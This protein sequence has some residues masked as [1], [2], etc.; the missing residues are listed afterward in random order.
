MRAV[1]ETTIADNWVKLGAV[2]GRIVDQLEARNAKA[3]PRSIPE[4]VKAWLADEKLWCRAEGKLDEAEMG[5]RR[6][7]PIPDCIRRNDPPYSSMDANWIEALHQA[8]GSKA[9][10]DER[11]AAYNAHEAEIATAMERAGLTKH[12]A[13]MEAWDLRREAEL[14]AIYAT[15]ATCAADILAKLEIG[16]AS[17]EWSKNV[18]DM[19]AESVAAAMHDL[20][21]MSDEPQKRAA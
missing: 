21:R 12:R 17:A 13:A 14:A 4:R 9:L 10:R 3:T 19:E 8:G 18:G 11:M 2:V 5:V 15:P 16:N 7:V 20:R 6:S 1:R